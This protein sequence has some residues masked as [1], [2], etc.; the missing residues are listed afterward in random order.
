MNLLTDD[1]L[2]ARRES[3]GE[4]VWIGLKEI[5]CTNND[6]S[7]MYP[8]DDLELGALCLCISI[9]QCL[10]PPENLN[11]L[12]NRIRKPMNFEEYEEGIQNY[13]DWFNLEDEKYPFMQVKGVKA[14]NSTPLD[15]LLP[16]LTGG[17]NCTFV[18]E[19]KQAVSLCSGCAAIALFNDAS[20]APGFGGGFKAGLRGSAPITTL[21]QGGCLRETIWM[22]VL[23]M[24]IGGDSF[25]N[26]K[27]N[28]LPT[29]VDPIKEKT[30]FSAA[31]IGLMRGI[32]WQPAHIELNG[33]VHGTTCSCCGR[34]V[35]S[36]FKN[37]NKAKFNYTVTDI[38]THPHSPRYLSLKGSEIVQRFASFTT[39]APSWTHLNRFVVQEEVSKNNK[40]GQE[41]ALVIVQAK[42]LLGRKSN[43]I[44]LIIGGYQNNQA[45]ILDRRHE[46]MTFRTFERSVLSEIVGCG[47]KFKSALRGALYVF[48]QGMKESGSSGKIKGNGTLIYQ[49]GDEFFYKRTQAVVEDA[50]V[51]ID[52]ENLTLIDEYKKTLCWIGEAIFEELT[53][54]YLHDPQLVHTLAVARRTWWKKVRDIMPIE[55]E[56]ENG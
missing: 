51:S 29:W 49:T 13:I 54:P 35:D 15:K 10:W 14:S 8:R 52:S 22:N 44:I 25:F 3:D 12:K 17:T 45:T 1:F 36:V 48:S 38:W 30:Q 28:S 9:V 50:L 11:E 53:A 46:V 18:N 43:L 33:Q 23:S 34:K 6:Y 26:K 4:H 47:L 2:S 56:G 27:L 41:P 19:P 16:G 31:G 20:S 55:K 21:I 37:F 40:E 39:S 24:D 32:F 42:K 7:F 5:I